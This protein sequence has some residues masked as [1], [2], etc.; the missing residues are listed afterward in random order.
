[1]EHKD[2]V[3]FPDHFDPSQVMGERVPPLIIVG[4]DQEKVASVV[5]QK[6]EEMPGRIRRINR[7]LTGERCLREIKGIKIRSRQC[8][9]F[10]QGFIVFDPPLDSRSKEHGSKALYYAVC[11]EEGLLLQLL[12]ANCLTSPHDHRLS[13]W[14]ESYLLLAGSAVLH[15][16]ESHY[17]LEETSPTI[18]PWVGHQLCTAD[19]PALTL[20][21]I[22]GDRNWFKLWLSGKGHEFRKSIKDT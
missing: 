13:R 2:L 19:Q 20:L 3:V 17:L 1:M 22:E 10:L 6:A 9:I 18:D 11:E 12:P 14:I 5:S 7:D 15:T 4:F 21:R 16:D 8:Y